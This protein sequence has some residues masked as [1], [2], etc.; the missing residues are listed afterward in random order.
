MSVGEGGEG[1]TPPLLPQIYEQNARGSSVVL[2]PGMG[3]IEYER[4]VLDFGL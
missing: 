1:I 2:V 4:R 3:W